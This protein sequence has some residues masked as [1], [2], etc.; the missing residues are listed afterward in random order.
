MVRL[1]AYAIDRPELF[2]AL[3]VAQDAGCDVEVYV[4]EGRTTEQ[5]PGKVPMLEDLR[6]WGKPGAALCSSRAYALQLLWSA[7]RKDPDGQENDQV[8]LIVGSMNWTTASPGNQEDP[9]AKQIACDFQAAVASE[10][11]AEK[12]LGAARN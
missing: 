4:D 5:K 9:L 2:G 7:A 8:E 1:T 10:A 6:E 12:S 11:C 3:K